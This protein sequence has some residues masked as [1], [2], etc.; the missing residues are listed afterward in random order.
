MILSNMNSIK[1]IRIITYFRRSWTFLRLLRLG[2][3]L[4]LFVS[5]IQTGEFIPFVLA[6]FLLFQVVQN[7]GCSCDGSQNCQ[8][9]N[10][11]N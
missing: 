9:S 1:M 8:I 3:G 11:Q 4:V 7:K 10:K 5:G 2:I 6:G